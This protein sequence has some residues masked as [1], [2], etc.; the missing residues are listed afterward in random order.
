MRQQYKSDDQQEQQQEKSEDSASSQKSGFKRSEY[1]PLARGAAISQVPPGERH[2][3]R[4]LTQ[5]K[6]SGIAT[7]AESHKCSAGTEVITARQKA[8]R[9]GTKGGT[10][11]SQAEGFYHQGGRSLDQIVRLTNLTEDHHSRA[12]ILARVMRAVLSGDRQAIFVMP[13][14][15]DTRCKSSNHGVISRE[16]ERGGHN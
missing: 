15:G 9:K 11:G 7:I 14:D 2:S 4:T 6:Q 5:C 16:Q 1:D 13:T 3:M 10:I 12:M 8:S